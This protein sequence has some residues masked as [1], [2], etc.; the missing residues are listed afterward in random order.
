MRTS[1][2]QFSR[3][4]T[5]GPQVAAPQPFE[6]DGMGTCTETQRQLDSG[7]FALCRPAVS[8]A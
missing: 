5:C 7:A 4:A 1:P 2:A 8:C 6:T 3:S